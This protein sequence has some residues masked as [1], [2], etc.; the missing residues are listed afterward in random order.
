MILF[1]PVF[2]TKLLTKYL[3]KF[4]TFNITTNNQN[5]HTGLLLIYNAHR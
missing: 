3:D 4:L 2:Y 5:I 1:I